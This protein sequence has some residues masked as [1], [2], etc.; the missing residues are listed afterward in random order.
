M[1]AD[2]AIV[3]LVP[4]HPGSH[5]G[6]FLL[7]AGGDVV[8]LETRVFVVDIGGAVRRIAALF[9][10]R[11]QE[12]PGLGMEASLDAVADAVRPPTRS[13]STSRPT[14]VPSVVFTPSS[15]L[16]ACV[17]APPAVT[18]LLRLVPALP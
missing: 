15:W 7:L 18:L 4:G 8:A 6:A 11:V 1:P 3:V 17:V 16:R 13:H 2:V 12:V 14:D 9:D 10:H 5:A